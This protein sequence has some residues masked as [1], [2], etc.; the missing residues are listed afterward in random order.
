MAPRPA[1]VAVI[2]S[3]LLDLLFELIENQAFFAKT[4]L[5]LTPKR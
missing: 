3:D 2:W 5:K 1:F 4:T